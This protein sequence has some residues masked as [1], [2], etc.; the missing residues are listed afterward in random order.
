MKNSAL[1]ITAPVAA[2][3]LSILVVAW[4]ILVDARS[5]DVGKAFTS[6]P[7]F[8]FWLLVLGGQAA[9]WVVA[10]PYVAAT[11]WRRGRDLRA[12][13]ALGAVAVLSVALTALVLLAIS[14]R[15]TVG[16]PEND[17]PPLR[18]VP[19]GDAWPLP[20]HGDRVGPLVV[21]AMLVVVAAVVGIWLAGIALREIARRPSVD[22]VPRFVELRNEINMLLAIAGVVIGLGTLASGLL[23]EAVLATNEIALTDKPETQPSVPIQ[24]DPSTTPTEAYRTALEFDPEY[25]ALYGLFFTLLLALAFAPSYLALRSAARELRER[26]LPLPPPTADEF[27]DVR[28]KRQTLDELLQTNLAALGSFKA[29]IAILSPL[30]GSLTALVLGLPT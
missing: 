18:G 12:H 21:F 30:A 22:Q 29:G 11:V 19:S 15:F 25:V 17:D 26:T 3:L 6:T 24:D 5:T 28:Q 1:A 10:L 14:V 8:L 4:V 2:A 23:R 27:D 13:R 7:E 9:V 16:A 20:D